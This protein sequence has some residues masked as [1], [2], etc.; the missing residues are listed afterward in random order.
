MHRWNCTEERRQLR[1]K[2]TLMARVNKGLYLRFFPIDA[3]LF[4]HFRH[5]FFISFHYKYKRCT[6]LISYMSKCFDFLLKTIALTSSISNI[7]WFYFF[8]CFFIISEFF[9]Y[10]GNRNWDNFSLT[11]I[12]FVRCFFHNKL[13]FFQSLF[14]V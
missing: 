1:G 8:P 2:R 6:R 4:N 12:Q 7:N 11:K 10:I 5:P 14:V 13:I 9:N 3:N